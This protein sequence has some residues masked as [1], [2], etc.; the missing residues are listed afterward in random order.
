MT[1]TVE[2]GGV[3]FRGAVV[4]VLTDLGAAA[5]PA[6][7]YGET[8]SVAYD[9]MVAGDRTE[10]RD[11][12]DVV[13][14]LAPRHLLE[15]AAGT[16]RI[17][18]PLL[19]LRAPVVALEFSPHMIALLGARAAELPPARRDRLTVVPGDMADFDLGCTFDAVVLG[20]S[21]VSLLSASGRA[22]LLT[23]VLRH[24]EPGGTFVLTTS[25]IGEDAPR[26]SV[27]EV[28]TRGGAALD[29]YVHVRA[30]GGHRD[31]VLLPRDRSEQG[32]PVWHS[33]V[34]VVPPEVLTAELTRH[35]FVDVRTVPLDPTR[36]APAHLRDAL[37]T[38]R[39]PA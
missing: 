28:V 33:S 18:F 2:V 17:T 4:D 34:A 9:D 5:R 30:D 37:L 6:D 7:L 31:V 3:T 32:T 22:G 26:D 1:G 8:G 29:M 35:G 38:A 14:A 11:I 21:S 15:L 39:R 23:S 10:V 27:T 12:L 20:T 13:T 19:A 25:W 36:G 24:L 16:G